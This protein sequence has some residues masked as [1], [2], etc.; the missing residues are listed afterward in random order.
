MVKILLAIFS[1]FIS[2][3]S[4]FAQQFDARAYTDTS[5]YLIG[6]RISYKVKITFP[7]N[8]IIVPP[9]FLDSISNVDV[10]E[11]KPPVKTNNNGMFTSVYEFILSRYDS[12]NVTIPGYPIRY[13]KKELPDEQ[14]APLPAEFLTDSIYQLKI[15]NSVTFTVHTLRLLKQ[16]DIKD[17]KEPILIP[18]DWEIVILIILLL[19]GVLTL[20][21]QIFIYYKYKRKKEPSHAPVTKVHLLPHL[22]ALKDLQVLEEKQL[23]QK[24]DVKP[25]HSQITEIIR[26]YFEERYRMPALELSTS[27]VLDNLKQRSDTEGIRNVTR[28]FLNN[29]DLVK[30]ARFNPLPSVNEEMMIQAREI[31]RRTEFVPVEDRGEEYV[32]V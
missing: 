5:D 30:F 4:S 17:I 20:A 3:F 19:L 12:S 2:S 11:V 22:K 6:D 29:A 8:F 23:W 31:V 18:L 25:Y 16:E 27:E 21:V 14:A 1:V 7:E 10:W 26:K 9:N 13:K 15:T 28:D 32:N 24:G